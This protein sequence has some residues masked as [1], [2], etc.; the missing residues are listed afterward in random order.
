[1]KFKIF[2]EILFLSIKNNFWKTFLAENW[3][4]KNYQIWKFDVELFW[5]LFGHFLE[6]GFLSNVKINRF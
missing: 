3:S 2:V 1:M 6:G 4:S 5:N